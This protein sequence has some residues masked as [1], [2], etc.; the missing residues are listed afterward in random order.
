[1]VFLYICLESTFLSF[2][3]WKIR[4][5]AKILYQL[6]DSVQL[7]VFDSSII[8]EGTKKNKVIRG[9]KRNKFIIFDIDTSHDSES[10]DSLGNSWV[11]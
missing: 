4:G 8:L 5:Y 7:K 2:H 3:F 9:R 1:M 6:K 10:T 11:T